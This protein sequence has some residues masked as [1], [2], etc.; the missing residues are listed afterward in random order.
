MQKYFLRVF[1]KQK[2]GKMKVR[3]PIQTPKEYITARRIMK[4]VEQNTIKPMQ[5]I[6]Q[7]RYHAYLQHSKI[8]YFPNGRGNNLSDKIKD[9]F[10]RIKDSFTFDEFV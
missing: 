2:E 3:I 7:R 5:K 4:S 6:K 9:L 10:F 1:Y 8:G